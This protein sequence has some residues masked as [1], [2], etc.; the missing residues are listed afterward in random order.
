MNNIIL[1]LDQHVIDPSISTENRSN[2]Y[3]RYAARAVLKDESGKVALMFAGQRQYYKL[4]GG[5]IDDGEEVLTAIA[6]ELLEETG[7]AAEITGEIGLVEEWRDFDRMHQISYAF[8]AT[9]TEQVSNPAFTQ[10]ELDE[11]FE[12]RWIANIEEA[13]HLV[14]KEAFHDDVEV[15]FMAQRDTAILRAAVK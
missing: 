14:E 4:P 13:I 6:R 7:C 12:V 3:L 2:Y 10:S 11:G 15:R 5:G 8:T 1:A 9:K